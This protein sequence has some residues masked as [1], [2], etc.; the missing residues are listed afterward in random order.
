VLPQSVGQTRNVKS[1]DDP[2]TL[3]PLIVNIDGVHRSI[4]DS[5]P[6]IY[7]ID[8]TALERNEPKHDPLFRQER[9]FYSLLKINYKF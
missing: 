2:S 9:L 3:L 4:N 5:A 8:A 1:E 6:V 7:I